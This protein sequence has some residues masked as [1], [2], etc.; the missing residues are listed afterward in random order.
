[1]ARTLYSEQLIVVRGLTSSSS[2]IVPPG[3]I[4]IL[5]DIDAYGNM[6]VFDT[7][8]LFVTGGAGQTIVWMDWPNDSQSHQQWQGR[9]VLNAGDQL[10]VENLGS[11]P[12]DVSIS[13]YSLTAP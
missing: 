13:G 9:Q 5:R 4:W 7:A 12:I 2:R 8:H 1:M 10:Q 11:A 3:F 6:G